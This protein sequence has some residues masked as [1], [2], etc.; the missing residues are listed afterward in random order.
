MSRIAKGIMDGRKGCFRQFFPER[1][2]FK[3]SGNNPGDESFFLKNVSSS[4][5]IRAKNH[6]L[7]EDLHDPSL[8]QLDSIHP[9]CV[10]KTGLGTHFILFV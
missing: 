8:T 6:L 4:L 9:S 10:P 3:S 1:D 7:C 5:K 2:G